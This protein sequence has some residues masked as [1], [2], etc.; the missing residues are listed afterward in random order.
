MIEELDGDEALPWELFKLLL[1]RRMLEEGESKF[2]SKVTMS[3][4]RSYAP[5]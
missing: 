1:A 5:E 4:Y 2:T 3:C